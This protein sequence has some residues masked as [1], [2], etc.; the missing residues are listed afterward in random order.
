MPDQSLILQSRTLLEGALDREPLAQQRYSKIADFEKDMCARWVSEAETVEM[1]E[2][3]IGRLVRRFSIMS[4]APYFHI[5]DL[6]GAELDALYGPP[7]QL[8]S[9]PPGEQEMALSEGRV[10]GAYH[11]RNFDDGGTTF[12]IVGTGNKLLDDVLLVYARPCVLT[13]QI[14]GWLNRNN[15]ETMGEVREW[16][17]LPEKDNSSK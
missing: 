16:F 15:L 17:G 10:L 12:Y 13:A 14:I 4:F 11:Y 5:A 3:R 6:M 9:L 2:Q 1:R 7:Q 8:Q